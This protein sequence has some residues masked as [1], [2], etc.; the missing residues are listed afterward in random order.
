MPSHKIMVFENF[1]NDFSWFW[2][3][4]NYFKSKYP[5]FCPWGY[6]QSSPLNPI[7]FLPMA[8]HPFQNYRNYLNSQHILKII[9][10]TPM[11]DFLAEFWDVQPYW[12]WPRNE[13]I[14]VTNIYHFRPFQ[15]LYTVTRY[16]AKS[17]VLPASNKRKNW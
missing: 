10:Y 3:E 16:P 7:L 5:I 15:N 8:W 6:P 9:Y 1:G 4:M 11:N 13:K 14:W 17:Y 2:F 12:R